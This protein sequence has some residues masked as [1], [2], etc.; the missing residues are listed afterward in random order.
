MTDS[1]LDKILGFIGLLNQFRTIERK[2]LT[3]GC[4]RN[5]ND[6][7]HSFSLAMLAWYVNNVYEL[8]LD[9]D[10]ML[11]YALVHDLVE[12]YAG[13]TF[14]YHP[15]RSFVDGKHAREEAAAQKLGTEYPEFPEIHDT[16]ERYEKRED[17]ESRFIYALDKIEPV[18]HIYRDKGR[19]WRRDGVTLEMLVTMKSPKVALDKT[20]E[21]IFK[22]LVSRVS[23]EQ[24]GLFLKS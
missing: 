13:D 9:T 7:E 24:D 20:V 1:P 21:G 4:D 5:E 6:S 11:K 23:N 8:N 12:A 15:D 22:E 19:S 2:V 14:F 3:Q 17:R 16:I 18:L 10:T